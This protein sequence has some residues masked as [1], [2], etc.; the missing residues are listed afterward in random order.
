MRILFLTGGTGF[1]GSH[2]AREFLA[3]GWRVR[4]LV[5]PD[6]PGQLPR[7]VEVVPGDLTAAAGHRRHLQGCTAVRLLGLG[8][9]LWGALTRTTSALNRD[10]VRD[11]L[12]SDWLC[13]SEPFLQ[14]LEVAPTI[15]WQEGIRNT[16]RWYI[17]ARW[18]APAAF[19]RI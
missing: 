19:A 15:R 13:D 1:V 2:V 6:R 11:M 12:Q 8:A 14:D 18:L 3:Q 4:A 16:C 7:G 17:E 10:K 5:R 9:S